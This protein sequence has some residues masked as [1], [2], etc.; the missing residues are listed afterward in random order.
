MKERNTCLE[1][2]ITFFPMLSHIVNHVEYNF[3]TDKD[4]AY[5]SA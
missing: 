1:S 3:L 2:E 4:D 5:L